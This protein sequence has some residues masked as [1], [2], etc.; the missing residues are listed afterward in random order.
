MHKYRV[1]TVGAV[2][3]WMLPAAA[4]Q[5]G[6]KA[7]RPCGAGVVSRRTYP[8]S[9]SG[10][11]GDGDV[12]ERIGKEENLVLMTE[13]KCGWKLLTECGSLGGDGIARRRA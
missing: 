12:R 5:A 3:A 6:C 11:K 4:L 7:D 1:K 10:G 2:G 13:N 8:C 9:M